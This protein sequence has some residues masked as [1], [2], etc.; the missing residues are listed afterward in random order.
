MIFKNSNIVQLLPELNE[1]GVERGVVELNREFVKRGIKSHVISKGGKLVKQIQSDG[2]HHHCL[3]ICDKNPFS[4]PLRVTQLRR[5]LRNIKPDIIHSRSRYPAWISWFANKKLNIPYVTTVHGMNSINHYSRI[6]TTGDKVICVSEVIQKYVSDAYP[7]KHDKL[8]VVQRG[9]DMDYFN[10]VLTNAEFKKA[11][12]RQFNLP[13]RFVVT[14]VGRVS[15]LKDYESFIK[16]VSICREKIPNITGLIVGGAREDKIEYLNSLKKLARKEGIEN[17]L[18][19]TGSQDKMPEIYQLSNIVVNAS[20]KMGNVGRTVVE[21]LAMNTPVLATSYPGLN[22]LIRDNFNGY[23]IK[24]QNVQDLCKKIQYLHEKPLKNTRM[25][26]PRDFTLKA[27][28]DDTIK[29]YSS[30]LDNL[31]RYN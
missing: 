2:G 30:L 16:A 24:K 21:A 27:M 14:G 4:L 9:V 5:I 8:V 31:R 25:S 29:V 1:G 10:P 23:I 26:I 18:H 12:S 15:W 20:L 28:V 13:G 7:I 22:N 6:M 17:C 11:F 19:F 3:N